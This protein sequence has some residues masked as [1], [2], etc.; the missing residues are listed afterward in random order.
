MQFGL[1]AY[2]YG[3]TKHNC[4]VNR[5]NSGR[6]DCIELTIELDRSEEH[7]SELQSH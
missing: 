5:D 2:I 6:I 7:T 3:F 1:G 4:Y